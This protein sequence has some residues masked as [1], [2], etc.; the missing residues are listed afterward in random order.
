[1]GYRRQLRVGRA[2]FYARAAEAVRIAIA[3]H[4]YSQAGS[5]T[6]VGAAKARRWLCTVRF[7]SKFLLSRCC[8]LQ[9]VFPV[10]LVVAIT[11]GVAL[12]L[13]MRFV[14]SFRRGE[15]GRR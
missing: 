12:F 2:T 14:Q 4:N 5:S 9:P 1:M 15:K 7:L 6:K 10:G 8:R 13:L 3:L 11:R